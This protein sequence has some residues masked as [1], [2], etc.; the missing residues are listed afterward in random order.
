MKLYYRKI[1][2]SENAEIDFRK[3][4]HAH[5][6]VRVELSEMMED[7][8][9]EI[10]MKALEREPESWHISRS[11]PLWTPCD[12]PFPRE[13]SVS[14]GPSHHLHTRLSPPSH[15]AL[16]LSEHPHTPTNCFIYS[17]DCW[18]LTWERLRASVPAS[19]SNPAAVFQHHLCFMFSITL[20]NIFRQLL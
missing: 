11:G 14:P 20:A 18:Y 8:G 9:T 7:S 5:I 3:I 4:W 17:P 13:A 16:F 12:P 1:K 19:R 15:S 10:L 6:P 2:G